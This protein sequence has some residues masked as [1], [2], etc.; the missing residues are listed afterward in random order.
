MQRLR[1][2]LSIRHSIVAIAALGTCSAACAGQ[3]FNASFEDPGNS[4]ANWNT[5]NN[6]SNNVAPAATT[7]RSG[8]QTL[9]I[10]GSF[11]GGANYSGVFQSRTASP[12]QVWQARG[13]FRHNTGDPLLGANAVSLKVEFYRVLGGVYG[14]S[15]MLNEYQ[16]TVLSAASPRDA[17]IEGTLQATAPATTVEARVSIV[18]TQTSNSPGA[19]LVDDMSFGT[20]GGSPASG[21]TMVWNDEFNGPSI[22]LTKWRVEDLHLIKNNELQYYAPDEVYLSGG[23]LVLR[24]RQRTYWGFDS[25]GVWRQFNYTSGL[26]ESPNK[27]AIPYGRIEVRG[28]V[29]ST[30]GIWPAHWMLPNA[31]QWPPEIDIMEL[32]GHEPTRM[33]M[34]NHFGVWPNNQYN[35]EDFSGPN[36]AADM[37]TYAVEWS[38]GRLDF[39]VDGVPRARHTTGVAREPFYIILNTA[40]GGQWPGNPDGSTVFPQHHEIDYVRVYV[41]SD[42]GAGTTTIVDTTPVG[43]VVDGTRGPTEYIGVRSGINTGLSDLIGRNSELYIDS[44]TSGDL[45]LA[46]DSQ[47][48][49][50]QTGPYGSVIYVDCVDGGQ[51]TTFAMT[52]T[53]DRSRRMAS[54][55]GSSGQ[56]SDLYFADGFL[57]DYAIVVEPTALRA[58]QLGTTSHTLIG[59]TLL[60]AATDLDGGNDYA[61]R[62]DNGASSFKLREL[63]L[64]LSALGVAPGATLR[65]VATL[66]N[67]DTAFRANEFVGPT[68][69][70]TWDGGNPGATP[71]VLKPN[72]FLRLITVDGCGNGCNVV[73]GDGDVDNDCEVDLSDLSILLANF[74]ATG[75]THEQGD[76]DFNT[77]VDLS[78]L[79]KML[80]VF[81]A[82]CE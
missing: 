20:V 44:S 47:N 75:R 72:D 71:V 66:L 69:G 23:K 7:P 77:L 79:S 63:R 65:M 74:G 80:S 78:D 27:F 9:K 11:S 21:W 5:F 18:H 70:N 15:D 28:K 10:F 12:G 35:T 60:G 16:T 67:G 55:K 50:P 26:V 61:Y 1:T 48:A 43:A 38:P 24:S 41:P 56:R 6:V 36:F 45:H 22:D 8:G 73:G 32:L 17:W 46:F 54:G 25:N 82:T 14:T 3:I 4:I 49:W 31:G 19:T 64:P 37:H 42:P 2:R 81:G 13:F 29:P 52:D 59:G 33:Y 34:S 57:A 53:A 76:V 58:Y 30:R 51:F 40:V 39:Y 68:G 62:L